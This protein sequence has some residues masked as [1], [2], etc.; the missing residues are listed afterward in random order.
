MTTDNFLIEEK[1]L[2]LAQDICKPIKDSDT[3]NRALANAM[4]ANIAAKFF[5]ED[6]A[7][8]NSGLHNI[9]AVLEDIDIADIYIKN[10]Y[11]DVRVFFNEEELAVPKAHFDNN[12]LP[13]AYMFIKI[14]PDLS[15]GTV[16]GFILPENIDTSIDYNGY[17]KVSYDSL[18]SY[19]DIDSHLITEEDTYSVEDKDIFAYLDNTIED[20]NNFYSQLIASKDGRIRLAKAAKAQYIFNFVSIVKEESPADTGLDSFSESEDALEE[21]PIDFDISSDSAE[22]DF[23]DVEPVDLMEADSSAEIEALDEPEALLEE[24]GDLNLDL[25]VS[26]DALQEISEHE[27]TQ[28]EETDSEETLQ[29]LDDSNFDPDSITLISH[30]DENET[31]YPASSPATE[32]ASN[33]DEE[34]DL[35]LEEPENEQ[36]Q[37]NNN[38]NSI[39]EESSQ[40]EIIDEIASEENMPAVSTSDSEDIENQNSSSAY[41]DYKTVTSPSMDIYEELENEEEKD[42]SNTEAPSHGE[43]EIDSLFG[44]TEK[45]T[46]VTP[47]K[48]SGSSSKLLLILVFLLALGGAGYFGI[49]KFLQSSEDTQTNLVQEPPTPAEEPKQKQE[50]DA[51]PVETVESTKINTDQNEGTSVSIPAIEQNLDASILV[52]NLK[53]DWEVPSGYAS[54][55]SARRY[56]VKLG[57]IVQLNL[58]TELLLLSKPPISNKIGVEIKYN[59]SLKKFETVGISTSSGEETVDDVILKTVQRALERKLNINSDSFAKLQGNPILIIRL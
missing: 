57:K 4:A 52:S 29:E 10:C 46:G 56:L 53:V 2:E 58:K 40:E 21:A 50:P 23:A 5:E 16:I 28:P 45:N 51:M 1:D 3:K 7:D 48:K 37:Q 24:S 27:S 35:L 31:Y 30:S 49:T 6:E 14:T 15:G 42:S 55:S 19:Y 8:F 18:V 34:F 11:I 41:E 12:L 32:E 47:A 22:L 20:K 17:Y 39:E 43:A 44:S 38:F 36:T 9:A 26:T 13:A 25:E 54:N 59:P 33:E